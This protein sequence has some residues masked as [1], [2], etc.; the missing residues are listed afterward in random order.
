MTA[1]LLW[2]LLHVRVAPKHDPDAGETVTGTICDC[3]GVAAVAAK[4]KDM[5]RLV[6]R[7]HNGLVEMHS[8]CQV[9]QQAMGTQY[10]LEPS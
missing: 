3:H 7:M 2:S 10:G 4:H 9:H 6:Y 5:L 1:V 8:R